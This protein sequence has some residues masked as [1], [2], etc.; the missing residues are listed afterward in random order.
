MPA[1]LACLQLVLQYYS[2]FQTLFQVC[3]RSH[4]PNER[5]NQANQPA[6]QLPLHHTKQY[7]IALGGVVV[8][9]CRSRHSTKPTPT[10]DID[11]LLSLTYDQP[12]RHF[13]LFLLNVVYS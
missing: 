7:D 13:R 12:L 2:F 4:T 6:N 5:T 1:E 11:M 3:L 10:P 8:V 9:F